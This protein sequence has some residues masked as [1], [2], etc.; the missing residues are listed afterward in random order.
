MA[1]EFCYFRHLTEKR[2][3]QKRRSTIY[4]VVFSFLT[5]VL[6]E[7]FFEHPCKQELEQISTEHKRGILSVCAIRNPHRFSQLE[8]FVVNRLQS[9]FH[10]DFVSGKFPDLPVTVYTSGLPVIEVHCWLDDGT[11]LMFFEEI[12]DDKAYA[13]IVDHYCP[14]IQPRP[15]DSTSAT[16]ISDTDPIFVK[17]RIRYSSKKIE[18]H[19]F[20]PISATNP[21]VDSAPP[22]NSR[23][24]RRGRKFVDVGSAQ[25]RICYSKVDLLRIGIDFIT[26][27]WRS[28]LDILLAQ[29]QL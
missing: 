15:L 9:I 1:S 27:R 21:I 6:L 3:S 2:R 18:A 5:I 24:T 11:P 28:S 19:W 13:Y 10:N 7:L 26:P 14:W 22:T 23:P 17:R 25:K 29:D 4:D 16:A 12:L 8:T 20:E